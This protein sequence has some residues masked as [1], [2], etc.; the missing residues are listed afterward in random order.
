VNDLKDENQLYH[1]VQRPPLHLRFV[2]LLVALPVMFAT[3]KHV[4]FNDNFGEFP[5]KDYLVLVL[6]LIAGIILPFYY[7]RSFFEV[8]LKNEVISIRSWPFNRTP[9]RI[10]LANLHKY[11]AVSYMAV[12]FLSMIR[13]HKVFSGFC[14][15]GVQ[16]EYINRDQIYIG[17]KTPV[18]LVEAI[19]LALNK[20]I[21]KQ[22]LMNLDRIQPSQLYIN[23][24]D[25]AQFIK[26]VKRPY[27]DF[28]GE[29][30]VKQI[31]GD[32]VYADDHIKPFAAYFLGMTEVKINCLEESSGDAEL[33]KRVD[34]CRKDG[35]RTIADLRRRV[36]SSD[37]YINLW[38]SRIE[39]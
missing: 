27:L 32:F 20:N 2:I 37:D 10:S 17:A 6:G 28:V 15:S 11:R 33:K 8:E 4:F 35:I 39:K 3:L 19:D 13:R 9:V 34:W 25:L 21:G 18:K 14:T 12:G 16:L 29:I 31:N 30:K 26:D 24:S 38:Q 7:L 1:E 23:S 5:K 36:V 22:I